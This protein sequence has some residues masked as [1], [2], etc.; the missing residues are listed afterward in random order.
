VGG[1]AAVTTWAAGAFGVTWEVPGLDVVTGALLV[2]SAAW[3]AGVSIY[4]ERHNIAVWFDRSMH[5][6]DNWYHDV[7]NFPDQFW[8]GL[9]NAF[10]PLDW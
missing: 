9:R 3:T 1:A 6:V 8:N 10:D 4:D 2:G 7:V 5:D